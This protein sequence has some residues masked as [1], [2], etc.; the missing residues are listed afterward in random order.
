MTVARVAEL[1]AQHPNTVRE[2][3]EGLTGAGLARRDHLAPAGR[4]RPASVYTYSP[5]ASFASPEY[6]VLAQVLVSY[7]TEVLPDGPTLRHHAREA[8]R[9]WGRTIVARDPEHGAATSRRAGGRAVTGAV[10][11]LRQRLDRVGFEPEVDDDGATLRLHRCPVLALA[12]EHPHVVCSAHLGMAREILAAEDVDADKVSLEAF[13]EPGACLLHVARRLP[14]TDDAEDGLRVGP[15]RS[16][17][18]AGARQ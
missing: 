4:G 17:M 18:S 14:G 1:L 13:V 3:L 11:H 2:H 16:T 7:L 12:Q 9:A 10:E 6:A 8:G 15:L 5:E